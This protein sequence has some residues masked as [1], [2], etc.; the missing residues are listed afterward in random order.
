[1][2]LFVLFLFVV[3]LISCVQPPQE[4]KPGG[5]YEGF[6]YVKDDLFIAD[7]LI[8]PT[9]DSIPPVWTY[10]SIYT[11][12]KSKCDAL[13]Y[14]TPCYIPIRRD[15]GINKEYCTFNNTDTVYIK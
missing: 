10:I 2:K 9:C 4:I 7:K 14:H 11:T 5:T 12:D 15:W 3:I 6:T 1:M 13:S 8:Y